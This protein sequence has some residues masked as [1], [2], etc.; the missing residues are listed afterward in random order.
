MTSLTAQFMKIWRVAWMGIATIATI[1]VVV[2]LLWPPAP[3]QA[4][5]KAHNEKP[6]DAARLD[7]SLSATSC[8]P[9][10]DLTPPL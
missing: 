3:R 1:A 4:S 2:M 9:A 5:A 7:S 8:R 6:P 10:S